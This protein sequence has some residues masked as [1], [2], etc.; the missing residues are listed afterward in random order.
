MIERKAS[1]ILLEIEASIK[2]IEASIKLQDFQQKLIIS[3]LNKLF[4]KNDEKVIEK[5]LNNE[6]SEIENFAAAPI[7]Q[8]SLVEKKNRLMTIQ[9]KTAEDIPKEDPE[10]NFKV[11]RR[12]V[13]NTVL[14]SKE[15]PDTKD[16]KKIPVTQKLVLFDGTPM[17]SATVLI[18]NKIGIP[19]RTL[20]TN[21]V[22]RWNVS[23][24]PGKY[25][26]TAKGDFGDETIEFSQ[27]FEVPDINSPLDLPAPQTYKKKTK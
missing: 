13:N 17:I 12:N 11:E 8:E 23:L 18:K 21:Q 20:T 10:F 25:S 2:N 4:N 22:G 27:M 14:K 1:E 16:V 26:L 9:R 5:P 3:N 19:I 7:K 6:N 24:V 15:T